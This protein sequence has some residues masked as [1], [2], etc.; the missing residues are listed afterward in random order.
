MTGLNL[1]GFLK[2]CP[3]QPWEAVVLSLASSQSSSDGWREKKAITWWYAKN[4][5]LPPPRIPA[6][7]PFTSQFGAWNSRQLKKGFPSEEHNYGKLWPASHYI[8][9][10]GKTSVIWEEERK[11]NSKNWRE[12]EE[13]SKW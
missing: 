1:P 12:M 2:V 7:S 6:P 5:P 8:S 11:P 9:Q 10:G 13:S 3:F 4:L